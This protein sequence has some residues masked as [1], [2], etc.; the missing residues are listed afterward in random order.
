MQFYRGKQIISEKGAFSCCRNTAEVPHS[1][2]LKFRYTKNAKTL[3]IDK[4]YM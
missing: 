1:A 4:G 3:R 2:V